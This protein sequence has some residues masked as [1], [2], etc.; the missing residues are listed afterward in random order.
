M[1]EVLIF[2]FLLMMEHS[3]SIAIREPID[4]LGYFKEH[5]IYAC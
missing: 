2:I 1:K 3:D 4:D 5:V